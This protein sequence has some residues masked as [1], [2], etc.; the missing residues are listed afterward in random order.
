MVRIAG[1]IF[2]LDPGKHA[3]HIH[4]AADSTGDCQAVGGHFNPYRASKE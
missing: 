3:I 2:G 1:E 4:E